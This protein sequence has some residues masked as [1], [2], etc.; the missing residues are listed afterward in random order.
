MMRSGIYQI[1]NTTSGKLYIGS[2]ALMPKRFR[3]H[4]NALRA[5]RHHSGHLQNA[6]NRYEERAFSFEPLFICAPSDLVFFE[7]RTIDALRSADEQFGYNISPTAGSP[8]GVKRTAELRKR[9]S[10][11][12]M[13]KTPWN[14]GRPMAAETKR[15]VSVGKMGIAPWNKGKRLSAEHV[16]KTA[17]AKRGSRWSAATRAKM[18]KDNCRYGHPLSGENLYLHSKNGKRGCRICRSAA[19]VRQRTDVS[20]REMFP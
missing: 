17:A 6:W 7:Q 13:G 3:E 16:E 14:K 12:R 8:R 11:L 9:L 4:R 5:G 19:T 2:A 18:H 20:Q 1:R 15:R 10:A